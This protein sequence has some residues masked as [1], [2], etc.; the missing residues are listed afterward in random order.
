MGILADRIEQFILRKLLEEQKNVDE[1]IVLRRN[2]LADEL[3]CAPS[4]I[5]YVLSTRFSNDRGFIVESRRGL[6]GF[7]SITRIPLKSISIQTV[8]PAKKQGGS[9]EKADGAEAAKEAQQAEQQ[10]AEPITIGAVD[11]F[12]F[13]LIQN[14]MLTRREASLLHEAFVILMKDDKDSRRDANVKQLCQNILSML[15]EG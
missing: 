5:S 13:E 7:I 6:G 11:Q 9:P 15:K 14:K 2:E 10:Q 3:N 1:G 12:L 4:Q 8:Q